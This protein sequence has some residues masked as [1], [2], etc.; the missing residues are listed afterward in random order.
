MEEFQSC[1]YEGVSVLDKILSLT[2]RNDARGVVDG[3]I[4]ALSCLIE[5][6]ENL[7]LK[8]RRV[9]RLHELYHRDMM[10]L[11]FRPVSLREHECHTRL[12]HRVVSHIVS[13]P[14]LFYSQDFL[15]RSEVVLRDLD[16][17]PYLIRIRLELFN[18]VFAQ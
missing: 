18:S 5:S 9:D 11:A 2:R 10:L 16:L 3:I 6:L 1:A 12:E 8:L 7:R 13:H 17:I 4:P 15:R 14:P